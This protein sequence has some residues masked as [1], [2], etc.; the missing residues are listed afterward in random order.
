MEHKEPAERP[1][2]AEAGRVTV[3]QMASSPPRDSGGPPSTSGSPAS[4]SKGFA[5]IKPLVS[6]QLTPAMRPRSPRASCQRGD[7]EAVREP[8]LLGVFILSPAHTSTP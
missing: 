7:G 3:G 6:L 2:A 4:G 1:R 8:L 5:L